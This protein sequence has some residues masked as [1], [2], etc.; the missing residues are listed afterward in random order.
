MCKVPS[1][2]G[3]E[4]CATCVDCEI[5]GE[6]H[7][8]QDSQ[9]GIEVQRRAYVKFYDTDN[10]D[11]EELDDEEDHWDDKS[12]P[13]LE[14]RSEL[15]EEENKVTEYKANMTIAYYDDDDELCDKIREEIDIEI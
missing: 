15:W 14:A 1:E 10:E 2:D 3:T 9:G 12:I 4:E 6:E 5:Q 8:L 13:E 7:H 11:D